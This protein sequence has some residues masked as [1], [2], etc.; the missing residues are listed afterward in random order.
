MN[1]GFVLT[2]VTIR[3][4]GARPYKDR[5]HIQIWRRSS[6]A[7][8]PQEA[9]PHLTFYAKPSSKGS[10]HA[11]VYPVSI[12]WASEQIVAVVLITD[13]YLPGILRGASCGSRRVPR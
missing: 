11:D 8:L 5:L 9:N 3:Q 4:P 13:S 2:A 10:G 6:L 12:E 7:R 1:P